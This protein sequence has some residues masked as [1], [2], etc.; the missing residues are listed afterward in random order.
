MNVTIVLNIMPLES[1]DT[2]QR[3]GERDCLHLSLYDSE[4][5]FD[6]FF[7]IAVAI[8]E[9]TQ[10]HIHEESTFVITFIEYCILKKLS[11]PQ[12]ILLGICR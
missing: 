5:G 8:Y 4:E 10:R 9:T 7:E 6:R 11:V 2:C 12:D 1:L 3:F